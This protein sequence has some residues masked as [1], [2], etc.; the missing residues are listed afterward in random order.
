MATMFTPN[1]HC[2]SEYLY[3]YCRIFS[4]SPSFLTSMT[5]RMPCRSLSS[6]MSPMPWNSAFFSWLM[7]RIFSSAAALLT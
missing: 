1:V 2:R 5:A 6:R 7:A 3:R 4:G